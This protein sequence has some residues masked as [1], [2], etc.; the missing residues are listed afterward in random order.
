MCIRIRCDFTMY[1][2]IGWQLALRCAKRSSPV[3]RGE[4]FGADGGNRWNSTVT[5]GPSTCSIR[6]SANHAPFHAGGA[7]V[8]FLAPMNLIPQSVKDG[9]VRAVRPLARALIRGGV[10]P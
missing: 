5:D 2:S 9:F 6:T 7:V 8:T 10:T 1:R 3:R 4:R